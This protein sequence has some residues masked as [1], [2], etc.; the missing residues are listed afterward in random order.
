MLARLGKS[1][2]HKTLPVKAAQRDN[3]PAVRLPKLKASA[4]RPVLKEPVREVDTKGLGRYVLCRTVGTGAF[5]R[6]RLALDKVSGEVVVLKIMSKSLVLRR[7]QLDHVLTERELLSQLRHPFIVQYKA[8]FQDQHFLYMVLEYVQGGELYSVLAREGFVEE[9]DAKVYACEVLSALAYLH[10]QHIVYRDL[11]PENV[12]LTSSGHVKLSDFGF[13][14]VVTERTYTLCGTP[15]YLAPEIINREGHNEQCDWW[16]LGVLLHEMVLGQA[17]FQASSPF[18]LY[19]QILTKEVQLPDQVPFATRQLITQLLIKDP[20]QRSNEAQIRSSAYFAGVN[21]EQV[22][23]L[24]LQPRYRPQ[25]TNRSDSSHF[26]KYPETGLP[27][28][29]KLYTDAALFAGYSS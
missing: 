4:S 15:E 10:S 20:R 25:V 17:P 22:A 7:K 5:A 14:K 24:R 27:I 21:W 6:V 26:E 1:S 8:A 2:S 23:Q 3:K 19:E 28:D 9:H 18:E 12:L 29:E 16:A 13:A 11:K